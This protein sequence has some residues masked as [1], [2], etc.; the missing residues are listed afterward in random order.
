M[1]KG[2]PVKLQWL[3]IAVTVRPEDIETVSG[4][5]LEAGTGGV[6]IEDPALIAQFLAGPPDAVAHDALAVPE[7]PA[8][9]AYLPVDRR[10]AGRLAELQKSLTALYPDLSGRWKARLTEEEDWANAWR[11]YYRPVRVGK[12]LVIRPSWVDYPAAPGQ[13]VISLDPGMAFG[14]GTHPTTVMCLEQLEEMLSGG[15]TVFDVGTGSGI[16]A[17]AAAVLGAGRVKAVDNDPLA[18]ATARENAARNGVADRVT[19]A[20][21]DLLNGDWGRADVVVANIVADAII[22]LIPSVAAVLKP[23]GVFIASGIIKEREAQVRRSLQD[24]GLAMKWE[25]RSGEWVAVAAG[26]V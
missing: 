5:L 16:L 17:V 6:V 12:S 21:G 9:K 8:V 11:A 20:A 13:K 10:L 22:R 4:L 3:E 19:V 2:A 24:G 26:V 14:C 23:G 15:E 7:R 18:V 1:K 25:G